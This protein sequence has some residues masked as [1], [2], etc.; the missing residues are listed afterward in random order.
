MAQS[1]ASPS[2]EEIESLQFQP[3]CGQGPPDLN[4]GGQ[5]YAWLREPFIGAECLVGYT[6]GRFNLFKR[7]LREFAPPFTVEILGSEME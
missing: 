4:H 2:D 5:V 3:F 6:R 7:V 1:H